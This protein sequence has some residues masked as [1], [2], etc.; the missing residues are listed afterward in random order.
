MSQIIAH[1]WAVSVGQVSQ[2]RHGAGLLQIRAKIK[3]L[4]LI[5]VV[6]EGG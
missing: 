5:S 1:F 2:R 4:G 3:H 6:A